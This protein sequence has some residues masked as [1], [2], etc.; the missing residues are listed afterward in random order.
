[1]T[2]K[3]GADG[4]GGEVHID[5]TGEGVGDDEGRGAQI[6]RLGLRMDAALEI[7]IAAQHG[8]DDEVA[9]LD[10]LF[11]AR[12]QRTAVANAGGASVCNREES[13]LLE[14][15]VQSRLVHV[16]RDHPRTGGETAFDGGGNG[17]TVFDG[18]FRQ[19]PGG[20]QHMRVGGVGAAGDRGEHHR[21]VVNGAESLDFGS[22]AEL[23][24]GQTKTSFLDRRGE[25]LKEGGF[26]LADGETILRAFG[27]GDTRLEGGEIEL[28]HLVERRFR[29]I[30]GAEQ[31]LSL[32][33]FF[34]EFDLFVR[35]AGFAQVAKGLFI[36]RE[37]PHRRAVF[38]RHV[39]NR[40]AVGERQAGEAGAGEFDEVT[41][42][43]FFAQDV[44]D[45]QCEV[46]RG[47]TGGNFAS[48]AET[49]DNR[50]EQRDRLA[51]HGGFRF[52]AAYAPTK[53]ADTID[54][55]GVRVGADEGVRIS[56]RA[57][58]AVRVGHHA[59]GEIFKIHLMADAEAGRN[60]LQFLKRVLAPTEKPV[61]FA[62][63]FKFFF[64]VALERLDIFGRINLN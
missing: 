18:F 8:G 56:H 4:F 57:A 29:G 63:A 16:G 54:H 26:D 27:S 43:T 32:A 51:K 24:G 42:D 11:H 46:R 14:I 61:T 40:R 28:D 37:I 44:G 39:G 3:T 59:L 19:Q 2:V 62:V 13:K 15:C 50:G 36:N 38:R 25:V 30:F 45:G 64:H 10:R 47:N 35:A 52:D 21:S 33:V 1:M 49:G 53:H 48:E 12:I 34:H 60:N 5:A 23:I 22:L 6:I 58:G 9:V 41:D 7:A 20:Q 55:R 31:A 17:E